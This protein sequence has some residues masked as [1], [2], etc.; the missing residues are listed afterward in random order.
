MMNED[1]EFYE[2]LFG[3]KKALEN[4]KNYQLEELKKAMEDLKN[5]L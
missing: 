4:W 3:G 2:K 1:I 5:N